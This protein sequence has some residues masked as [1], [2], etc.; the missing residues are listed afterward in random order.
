M[1]SI[2]CN[3]RDIATSDRRALEHVLGQPL[4]DNQQ[5]MISVVNL[6][7]NEEQEKKPAASSDT[8]P[9]WFRVYEGLSDDEI[10]EIERIA[11]KPVKFDRSAE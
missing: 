11:L 7:S 10:A 8:L 4:R 3:V 1:E 5:L 2:T 6:K 9:D